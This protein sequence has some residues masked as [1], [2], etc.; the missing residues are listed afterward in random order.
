MGGFGKNGRVGPKMGGF[1]QRNSQNSTKSLK[2][3]QIFAH[4]WPNFHSIWLKLGCFLPNFLNSTFFCPIFKIK[5]VKLGVFWPNFK[6]KFVKFNQFF[7]KIFYLQ[8]SLSNSSA[9]S[10]SSSISSISSK[11]PFF[12]KYSPTFS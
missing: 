7:T 5:F 10:E 2:Y 3:H 8:T 1:S 4:F 9:I 6:I 11:Y 12:F